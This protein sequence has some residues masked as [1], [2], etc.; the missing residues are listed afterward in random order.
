[1]PAIAFFCLALLLPFSNKQGTDEG[2][3]IRNLVDR[4]KK[5]LA[6]YK[7]SGLIIVSVGTAVSF[8]IPYLPGALQFFATLFFFSSFAGF[9][10]L[11]Y[12]TGLPYKK[13]ALIL[14]VLFILYNAISGGMFTIVAYMGVTIFS[15]LLFL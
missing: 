9:L 14:F 11:Y 3:G 5:I 4:I 6:V 10:Y 7:T 1:M 12:T 8:A 13:W 2:E 15:F